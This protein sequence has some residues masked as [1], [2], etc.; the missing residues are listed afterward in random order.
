MRCLIDS[1]RSLSHFISHRFYALSMNRDDYPALAR[2]VMP[3]DDDAAST[4]ASSANSFLDALRYQQYDDCKIRAIATIKD[5]GSSQH[6]AMVPRIDFPTLPL[7][8]RLSTHILAERGRVAGS[9][10]SAAISPNNMPASKETRALDRV[11][12]SGDPHISLADL[13]KATK[14]SHYHTISHLTF[15]G[16]SY[17]SVLDFAFALHVASQVA[18]DYSLFDKNCYWLCATVLGILAAEFTCG[19]R[20]VLPA[21]A[22]EEEQKEHEIDL[23]LKEDSKKKKSR[24]ATPYVAGTFFGLRVTRTDST[25]FRSMLADMVVLY[26]AGVKVFRETQSRQLAEAAAMRD[27]FG[28]LQAVVHD[29]DV[30]LQRV[31][32]GVA[33]AKDKLKAMGLSEAGKSINPFTR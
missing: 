1:S 22:A 7:L 5:P 4:V 8:P 20:Y 16:P 32:V 14:R 19:R 18:R 10:L 9:S 29:K 17:P 30:E 26:R 28:Q 6:E 13:M 24:K 21:S 25:T 3:G 11:L 31:K 23:R 33:G 27:A 2:L 15:D 12:V